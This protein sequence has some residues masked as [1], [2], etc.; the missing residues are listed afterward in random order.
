MESRFSLAKRLNEARYSG[1]VR[2]DA[3]D[4]KVRDYQN[5]MKTL[6]FQVLET[7]LLKA[8]VTFA[9]NVCVIIT[10]DHPL[11]KSLGLLHVHVSYALTHG[12][13]FRFAQ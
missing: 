10:G 7:D 5:K 2:P 11:K 13:P 1:Y 6:I 4:G 8:A 12:C 3:G 9:R